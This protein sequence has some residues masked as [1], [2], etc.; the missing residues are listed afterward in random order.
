VAPLVTRIGD[1][2]AVQPRVIS[3]TES[4]ELGTRYSRDEIAALAEYA[5]AHGLLL[6]V[7]GSRL[8]NAAAALDC[9]LGA[10]TSEVRVDAVSLG[11]TKNGALGVEAVLLL[12][13]DAAG[14][15]KFLRKQSMQL[16]SKMRF[17][18]AQ[19]LALYD[20][21]L[22]RENAAHANA[23]AARL[24]AALDGVVEFTHPVEANGLFAVLPP[25][26]TTALQADWPFYV[27]DEATGEV[28][29]MCAWDTAEEDVDAFAA[30]VRA[31]LAPA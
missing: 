7:D 30:A 23:M 10:L 31:A 28:R 21:E 15:F 3:I 24:R 13:P 16:A 29:W 22:W 17:L 26:V 6:H 4:T 12:T 19:L 25:E 27:W 20:G 5:H 1:E 2:H 8:A 9:P 14:E 11:A 18:S